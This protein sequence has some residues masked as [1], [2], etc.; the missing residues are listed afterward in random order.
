VRTALISISDLAVAVTKSQ[1]HLG[2][3]GFTDVAPEELGSIAADFLYGGYELCQTIMPSNEMR[4][5]LGGM[6]DRQFALGLAAGLRRRDSRTDA[7]VKGN[8][9][10]L[11]NLREGVQNGR[12]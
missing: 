10:H 7:V 8:W 6:V 2:N 4:M 9:L 12:W 11:L 5:H 3:P 1:H